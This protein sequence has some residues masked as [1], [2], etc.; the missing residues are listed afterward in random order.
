MLL[1]VVSTSQS[2]FLFSVKAKMAGIRVTYLSMNTKE[3]VSVGRDR[4]VAGIYYGDSHILCTGNYIG[5]IYYV[6]LVDVCFSAVPTLKRLQR[7]EMYVP[8]LF[9]AAHS[10]ASLSNQ[11]SKSLLMIL[12][13]KKLQLVRTKQ[14]I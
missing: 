2:S 9:V 5:E 4:E 6:P 7:C 11:Y 12:L 10:V 14:L 3:R 8:V 1:N 13:A